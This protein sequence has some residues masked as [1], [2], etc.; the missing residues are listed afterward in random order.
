MA[1]EFAHKGLTTNIIQAGITQT[2]S[3]M[4]IPGGE[5]ML[6]SAALRNP[7]GRL[8]QPEDVANVIYLLAQDEAD[9]ING[10]RIV[11]DGGE[12]LI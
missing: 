8:T 5:A 10:A 1:V 6:A 4:M 3:L 7:Q 2:P 9:W 12:H 11:V